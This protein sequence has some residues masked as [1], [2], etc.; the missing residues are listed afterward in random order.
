[1]PTSKNSR[2]IVP[3]AQTANEIASIGKAV[4]IKGEVFS[5][6]D[7]YVDGTLEGKIEVPSHKLT[8]GPHGT[9]RTGVIQ[10]SAVEIHGTVQGDVNALEKVEI[11]KSAN[12]IG[13]IK[14]PRIVIED[15]A[16]F[17]GDVDIARPEPAERSS[18]ARA[19]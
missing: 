19:D 16:Y 15:G 5:K 13:N 6:Q 2:R 10:A 18:S 3:V 4:R 14:A 11:R 9:V 17:K 8:V 7:L 12:L 1:V